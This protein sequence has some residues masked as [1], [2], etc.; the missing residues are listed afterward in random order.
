MCNCI[1]LDKKKESLSAQYKFTACCL[2]NL[3]EC[4]QVKYAY[5]IPDMISDCTIY[6]FIVCPI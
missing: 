4:D 6:S 1:R 2:S 5:I 3:T